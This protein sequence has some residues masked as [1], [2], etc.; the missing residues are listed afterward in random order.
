MP[1]LLHK[2]RR[3]TSGTL[4]AGGPSWRRAPR[5]PPAPSTG[6]A[7]ASCAAGLPPVTVRLPE[8]PPVELLECEQL[9]EVRR[10]AQLRH[11]VRGLYLGIELA[12][13]DRVGRPLLA[14]TSQAPALTSRYEPARL[15]LLSDCAKMFPMGCPCIISISSR[16]SCRRP[17]PWLQ[18]CAG[19]LFR[20]LSPISITCSV[21]FYC[22]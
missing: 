3:P 15:R 12:A 2:N 20:S 6:R 14:L 17:A 18:Q 22:R 13:L 10:A 11:E 19:R 16:L 4:P 21:Y 9:A 5:P 7:A 1:G 8:Y